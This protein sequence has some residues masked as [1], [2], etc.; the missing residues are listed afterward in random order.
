MFTK[1]LRLRNQQI[2]FLQDKRVPNGVGTRHSLRPV[3]MVPHV[4]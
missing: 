4:G 3:H 2:E 1:R